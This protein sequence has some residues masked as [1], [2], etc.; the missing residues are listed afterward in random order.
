MIEVARKSPNKYVTATAIRRCVPGDAGS[1]MRMHQYLVSWGF[2]NGS[3]IGESAPTVSIDQNNT[4]VP[5][6]GKNIDPKW[7]TDMV[8]VLTAA[9]ASFAT[10]KRKRDEK[11][12]IDLAIDWNVVA[13]KVGRNTTPHDCYHKFLSLTFENLKPNVLNQLDKELEADDATAVTIDN[14]TKFGTE[15]LVSQLIDGVRPVVAQ[16]AID[17]SFKASGGDLIATQKASVLA[18]VANNAADAARKEEESADR[19]LQEILDQR[20]SKLENRLSL[21]DDLEC[22]FDA[23]RMALELERRDLY[24]LRC[25]HWFSGDS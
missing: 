16:A 2:I 7:T 17:A 4:Q 12:S 23:E 5:S 24:T 25:R 1:L 20:M 21:L 18:S 3:A 22:M 11:D 14:E 10:K 15:S 9:V 6:A 13:Q 19:I 8:N